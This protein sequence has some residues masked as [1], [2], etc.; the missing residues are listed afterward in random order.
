MKRILFLSCALIISLLMEAQLIELPKVTVPGLKW[1]K[2]YQFDR[3]NH[4]KVDYYDKKGKIRQSHDYDIYYQQNGKDFCVKLITGKTDI[5]T[6]FDLKNESAV[7]IF[8][9]KGTEPM[10]NATRFTYPDE[11]KAKRIDLKPTGETRE[12]MGIMC[13]AYIYTLK[14]Q[15]GKAWIAKNKK[16]SN[17]YGIFRASKMGMFHNTLETG[18]FVMEIES[19]DTKGVRTMMQTISLDK[20]TN[21]SVSFDGVNMGTSI[22]KVSYFNF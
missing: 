3:V 11:K 17:D 1:E 20:K 12:I 7:Q 9:S 4:F 2:I 8:S 16:T 22:N 15:N 14:K 5:E 19:E 6:V 18:G 21:Y 13:E 10:Y